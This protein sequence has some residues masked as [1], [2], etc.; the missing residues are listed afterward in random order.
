MR[1]LKRFCLPVI[2]IALS[3]FAGAAEPDRGALLAAWADYMAANPDT[4]AFEPIDSSRFRLTD[5]SL[6][7]DGE[8]R[9]L[10][11]IVRTIDDF[12]ADLPF[13][14]TGFVEFELTDLAEE[15]RQTQSYYYWIADRQTLY[16]S[17]DEGRWMT[18][19]DY[20]AAFRDQLVPEGS[21]SF[22]YLIRYGIWLLLIPALLLAIFFVGKQAN[23]AR[24]LMNE[25]A[26]INQQARQNIERSA[27]LQE[28]VINI[29][30]QSLELHSETNRLLEDI[31]SGLKQ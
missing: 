27:A 7:Y 25:A 30:R 12:G 1:A 29:S 2:W 5:S 15:R 4:E 20:Q 14:H 13:S 11:A 23:K 16:F 31:R 8:I 21:S 24:K 10:G 18:P 6:P 22:F 3:G 26:E 17:V 19:A 28:E 9:V